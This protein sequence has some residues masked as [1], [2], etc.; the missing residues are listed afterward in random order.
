MFPESTTPDCQ[1][2]GV[3]V[4]GARGPCNYAKT[5]DVTG[6]LQVT[7]YGHDSWKCHSLAKVK[8]SEAWKFPTR[9]PQRKHLFCLESS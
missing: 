3:K 8:G 1:V 4:C 5:I 7:G 6:G 2:Q 9:P